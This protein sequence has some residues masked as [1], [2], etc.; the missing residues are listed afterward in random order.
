MIIHPKKLIELCCIIILVMQILTYI[1]FKCYALILV[2]DRFFFSVAAAIVHFILENAYCR[3][4]D[5]PWINHSAR[6]CKIIFT[7]NPICNISIMLKPSR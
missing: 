4:R 3:T 6:Y 1:R 5:G 7:K 2:T